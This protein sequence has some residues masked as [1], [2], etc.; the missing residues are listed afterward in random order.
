M[1]PYIKDPCVRW[2]SRSLKVGVSVRLI[3]AGL[4]VRKA[5]PGMMILIW[6][7]AKRPLLAL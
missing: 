4:S 2:V 1:S 6:G 7:I 5:E 3:G